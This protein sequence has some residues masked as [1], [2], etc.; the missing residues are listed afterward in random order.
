M[1]ESRGG[2]RTSA[3]SGKKDEA[4]RLRTGRREG[5]R[6]G[7]GKREEALRVRVGGQRGAVSRREGGKRFEGGGE[8]VQ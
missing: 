5:V 8:G 1:G 7:E 2:A 6:G 3:C 4:L